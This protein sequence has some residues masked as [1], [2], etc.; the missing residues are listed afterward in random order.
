MKLL[1]LSSSNGLRFNP[2]T[3]RM[4]FWESLEAVHYITKSGH[5]GITP[6]RVLKVYRLKIDW[7]RGEV[8]AVGRGWE[9]TVPVVDFILAT[10]DMRSVYYRTKS[11][12]ETITSFRRKLKVDNIHFEEV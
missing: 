12:P 5:Q 1:K 10:R 4:R 6:G 7:Q 3:G 8:V 9:A 11:F 2:E